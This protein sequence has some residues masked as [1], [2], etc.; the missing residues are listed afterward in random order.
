LI[1]YSKQSYDI[2]DDVTRGN[3]TLRVAQ[4]W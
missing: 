3:E 1:K 2:L 4:T